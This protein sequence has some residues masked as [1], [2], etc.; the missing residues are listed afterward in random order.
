MVYA[1]TIT[2][3]AGVVLLLLLGGGAV[4]ARRAADGQW[5][6]LR[7]SRWYP[8]PLGLL[9]LVPVAGLLLFRFLP[10]LLLL[11]VILSLFRRGRVRG[12]GG[13]LFRL[14]TMGRRPPP[15][16]PASEERDGDDGSIEGTYRPLDDE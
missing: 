2:I 10:V 16:P 1:L 13:P 4:L 9:L 6:S 8:S 11:P 5:P 12:L 15:P 14:W 7:R 3:A